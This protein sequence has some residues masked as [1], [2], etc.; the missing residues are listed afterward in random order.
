M[1]YLM[2]LYVAMVWPRPPSCR[3]KALPTLV[4]DAPVSQPAW[5]WINALV[6]GLFANQTVILFVKM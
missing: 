1:Q 3:L 5:M 6:I 2:L 4:Q